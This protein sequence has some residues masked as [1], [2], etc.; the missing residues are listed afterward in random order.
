MKDYKVRKNFICDYLSGA[1][2]F[3]ILTLPS[4]FCK[5]EKQVMEQP[6]KPVVVQNKDIVT[7]TK[8]TVDVYLSYKQNKE[9]YLI[10]DFVPND[11]DFERYKDKVNGR[12]FVIRKDVFKAFTEMQKAFSQY[13]TENKLKVKEIYLRSAFRSYADQKYIWETKFTGATKMSK[14]I[15]G[16][17]DK[18]KVDIILEYS[19][20]PGTSRHHWGTD[21]DLNSLD[22][23]YFKEDGE[24]AEF[25]RW[26]LGNASKFGFCQPY[27]ERSLRDNKGYFEER[28]HWSY[29]PVSAVLLEDW[30][31][32]FQ[33]KKLLIKKHLGDEHIDA[34]RSEY[35]NSINPECKQ[36]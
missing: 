2:L 9:K 6:T 22:N 28:W 18:E 17:T 5:A 20:A 1:F 21:L 8:P 16:K 13:A 33:E 25:Y 36:K 24:G 35:V 12:T 3:T 23:S 34:L 4:V 32:S 27:T 29:R 11:Q 19:S 31:T 30:N 14:S 26:L 7:D 15:V 10:G